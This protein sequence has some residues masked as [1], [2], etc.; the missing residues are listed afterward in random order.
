[1]RSLVTKLEG[2]YDLL[3]LDSSPIHSVTDSVVLSSF[4]DATLLVVG[5]KRGR[6][7][8]VLHAREALGRASANVLGTVLNGAANPG[9]RERSLYYGAAPAEGT[10]S[11]NV[12]PRPGH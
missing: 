5:A 3:I 4:L 7:S 9:T 12:G 6:R 8:T 2:S 11:A 1:M 10:S